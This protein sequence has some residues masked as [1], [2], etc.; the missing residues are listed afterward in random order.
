MILQNCTLD[1]PH[2]LSSHD[3]IFTSVKVELQEQGNKEKYTKTYTKFNRQKIAW[4]S[5]KIPEY[6]QLAFS[7]LSEAVSYWNTPECIPVLSSLISKLLVT[8]GTQVFPTKSSCTKKSA[9]KPPLKIR[10]AR[11]TLARTFNAWKNAGKP[12]LRDH[13]LRS[14]Y[15]EARTNLQRI[16]RRYST[17][18]G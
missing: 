13:P 1:S 4:D 9:K 15:R 16:S 17:F 3:P 8:C 6:Q 12:S 5:S 14:A 7:A 10:Q 2:N 11:N 18:M